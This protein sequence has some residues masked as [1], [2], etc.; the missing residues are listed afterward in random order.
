MNLPHKEFELAD[1]FGGA[2]C[3]KFNIVGQREYSNL[4]V[5]QMIAKIM[6][7]EL[8]YTMIGYDTQ[9]P[10]HDFRYALSGE[11]MKRLGWEPKYDFE[12]RL[13]QM[14]KWTL[15]NSRWLKL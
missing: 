10:G 7:R 11:Y 8:K 3:P 13:D 1:D 5:A 14:I 6:G 9:R 15:K 4:E 12:V 2:T